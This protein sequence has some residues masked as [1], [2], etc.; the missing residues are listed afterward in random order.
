MDNCVTGLEDHCFLRRTNSCRILS[1]SIYL[2]TY[3]SLDRCD[4][5]VERCCCGGGGGGGC[6]RRVAVAVAVP[7]AVRCMLVRCFDF[8]L[9]YSPS[10][11]FF[12]FGGVLFVCLCLFLRLCHGEE[13]R[14][15]REKDLPVCLSFRSKIDGIYDVCLIVRLCM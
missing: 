15:E 3:L 5:G 12:F 14:K 7:V 2:P 13:C 9:Y 4:A 10:V 6:R 8:N 11:V 1:L